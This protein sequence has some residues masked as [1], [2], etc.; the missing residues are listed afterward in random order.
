MFHRLTTG[1]FWQPSSGI[2]MHG[3][4]PFRRFQAVSHALQAR[5]CMRTIL[6]HSYKGCQKKSVV[7]RWNVAQSNVSEVQYLIHNFTIQYLHLTGWIITYIRILGVKV[8]YALKAIL[9]ACPGV[10]FIC[11][12]SYH[13]NWCRWAKVYLDISLLLDICIQSHVLIKST[14]RKASLESVLLKLGRRLSME[15]A[16]IWSMLWEPF[17]G[18]VREL[19]YAIEVILTAGVGEQKSTRTFHYLKIF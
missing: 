14:K 1:F 11:C 4:G 13:Y 10:A 17:W 16:N 9:G 5:Q 3:T 6:L 12:W 15:S 7:N 19:H 2:H 8:H 18:L